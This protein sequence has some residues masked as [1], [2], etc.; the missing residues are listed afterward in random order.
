MTVV[1][2]FSA[3]PSIAGQRN[4]L[5]AIGSGLT[6][7]TATKALKYSQMN[8][9]DA[10]VFVARIAAQ[11]ISHV[12]GRASHWAPFVPAV[13]TASILIALA[14]AAVANIVHLIAAPPDSFYA[15]TL[16]GVHG[17]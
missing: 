6:G 12:A 14:V 7:L 2:T 15:A 4:A 5:L 9:T 11:S 17:R 16:Y 3:S 8:I 1:A 13:L 10:L